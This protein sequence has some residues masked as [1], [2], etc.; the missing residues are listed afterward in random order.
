MVTPICD[1]FT[2]I[3]L[4]EDE[5]IVTVRI[6]FQIGLVGSKPPTFAISGGCLIQQKPTNLSSFY[7]PFSHLS[8][9]L[10]AAPPDRSGA[11]MDL[12]DA[13]WQAMAEVPRYESL[14]RGI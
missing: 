6:F 1:I 13:L 12:T 2:P 9:V 4:G 3:Q 11:G 8:K 10:P 7:S 14:V 5:P